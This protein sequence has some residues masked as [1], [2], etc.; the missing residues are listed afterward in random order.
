[1]KKCDTACNT[2]CSA[3]CDYTAGTCAKCKAGYSGPSCATHAY[4][5]REIRKINLSETSY[6]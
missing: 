1:M 6:E 4:V 3:A 2:G 5:E